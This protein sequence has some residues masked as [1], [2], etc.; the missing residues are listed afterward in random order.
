MGLLRLCGIKPKTIEL[1]FVTLPLTTYAALRSKSKLIDLES[2]C[3]G[4]ERHVY[5]RIVV[6]VRYTTKI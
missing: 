1:V 5:L 4:D 6:S 2:E 3:V